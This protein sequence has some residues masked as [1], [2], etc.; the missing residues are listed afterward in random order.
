M[1]IFS[2]IQI[3]PQDLEV[4]ALACYP[5][6]F[7]TNIDYN[8]Y[9]YFSPS[10]P[11]FLLPPTP[12]IVYAPSAFPQPHPLPES[13]PTSDA[14]SPDHSQ[15]LKPKGSIN[16][17]PEKIVKLCN[18]NVLPNNVSL[19]L[20]FIRRVKKS[21]KIVE[22]VLRR[23]DP[24]GAFS[25]KRFYAYQLYLKDN[26]TDFKWKEGIEVLVNRIDPTCASFSIEEQAFYNKLCR[27]L[28]MQYL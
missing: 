9:N 3:Y 19:I 1:V 18:R 12:N 21:G 28:I 11:A 14:L 13:A 25:S 4:A 17:P 27:I 2:P 10:L 6:F 26:C 22:R 5:Y 8:Y 15:S 23:L 7:S 24:R 20:C 16:T